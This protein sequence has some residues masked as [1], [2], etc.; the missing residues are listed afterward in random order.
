MK[1]ILV[2]AVYCFIIEEEK[3]FKIFQDMYKLLETYPN[4]KIILTGAS[5]DKRELYGLDNMP[6][7]VFTLKH[8][9]EKTNPEYYKILL[10][11][12]N[13]NKEDV[14][15]FEHSIDAVKSAQSIGINTYFYDNDKK[16]LKSLEK[17]LDESLK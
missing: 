5:D 8:N 4:K 11:Q 16:D 14:V 13:L 17:F 7:E 1:T 3:R 2:D 9:P 10:K 15:Y 6:Y 12:F